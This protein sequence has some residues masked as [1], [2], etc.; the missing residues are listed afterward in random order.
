[1]AQNRFTAVGRVPARRAQIFSNSGANVSIARG[2]AP[3][4]AERHAISRGNADGR[5]AAHHHGDDHIR[6]LF[7]GGGEHIALLEREPGLV[8]E[9]DA[10]RGPGQRR[11]H[12]LLFY[13][14]RRPK[15][16]RPQG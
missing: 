11:N 14:F 8:D 6:H 4:R 12:S 5:R 15:P 2:I 13:L 10:L 16:R 7:I 9:A 3:D 1:M